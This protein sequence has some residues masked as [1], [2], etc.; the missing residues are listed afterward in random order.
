MKKVVRLTENDL[1]NIINKVI[2]ESK[3][4]TSKSEVLKMSEDELK[5]LKVNGEYL[6][7]KGEFHHFKKVMGNVT[8]S[9]RAGEKTP[10][11]LKRN[12]QS[13][14]VKRDDVKFD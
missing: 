1:V 3:K 14:K 10:S 7:V 8:C 5:E 9:F 13:I 6:G 2:S 11:G 12:T 4:S